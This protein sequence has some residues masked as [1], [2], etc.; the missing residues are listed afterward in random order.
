MIVYLIKCSDLQ[1]QIYLFLSELKPSLL[2]TWA[3][4]NLD[5]TQITL[6]LLNTVDWPLS[7]TDP[8]YANEGRLILDALGT[9]QNH[10]CVKNHYGETAAKFL[11]C[12]MMHMGGFA[13]KPIINSRQSYDGAITDFPCGKRDLYACIMQIRL[14]NIC[15]GGNTFDQP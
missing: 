12:K 6:T 3:W 9:R 15:I 7:L 13:E 4:T 14:I 1:R 11:L 5:R 8:R 2:G 10:L